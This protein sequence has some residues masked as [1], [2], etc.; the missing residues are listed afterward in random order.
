MVMKRNLLLLLFISFT[1]NCLHAQLNRYIIQFKNK[2]TNPYSISNPSAYL[3][4]KA[5]ARR[6]AYSIAIDSTDLPVTPRYVDSV[7]LAGTVTILNVSK[8]LNQVSIQTTDAAAL[9]KINSLTFVQSVTAIAARMNNASNENQ[10]TK[11]KFE[12]ERKLEDAPLQRSN[13][14]TS[15]FFSYGNTYNE[16]HLHNGEF[17]HNIGMR[18][19]N[20]LVAV[21]DAGFF[22]YTT[23]KAFDSVV[24][25]NQVVQT[26]D[27]VAREAN[28]V[29]DDSHGMS[30]FSAIGGN[31]PGSFVG[32]APKANFV[33]YR[34]E[35]VSSE[36][37]IEEHNWACG[38]ERADS[39][40]ADVLSTSLGYT[41]FDNSS[42]DH[43]YA[44]MN[45][46]TNISTKAA[47]IA[48]RKGLLSFVAAGNDGGNSWHYLSSPGDADSLVTV[49]AVGTN[50]V[51]GGFSSYGPSSDGR[52]KP[53]VA[54]LGVNVYVQN[55]NNTIGAGNGTSY[56]TPKMAG[57]GTC[58]WQAF[59]EYNNMAIR[60]ALIK[61]SSIYTTPDDRIGYGIPDM[62]KAF[63]VL[64]N[65]YAKVTSASVGN[66]KTTIT[67]KTKDVSSM[68]F[69]IERL[70]PGQT[71]YTKIAEVQGQGSILGIHN[72]S[73]D[74][75]LSNVP[76]GT[77]KYRIKQV[78]DTAIAGY[79][80]TYFDSASVI[81]ATICTAASNEDKVS[82]MP[83]PVAGQFVLRVET[84]Y[85]VTNLN[86]RITDMKGRLMQQQ[87][88]S[89]GIGRVD[90]P[91]SS[92]YF[93]RGSYTISVYNGDVLIG[94]TRLV[95]L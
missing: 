33:L 16:I 88:K 90:F 38:A 34:T 75:A 70:A 82:I 7:R 13:N 18:G 35:D 92:N 71:S 50:G 1:G 72:Y 56:A 22:H 20:M 40:G 69:E 10:K 55:P 36:Y 30:C 59:P 77:I 41:T 49:G 32:N 66:C 84:S 60:D 39:I 31:I 2:G 21:L 81:L 74:D 25:N 89:K 29:E 94:N 46:R 24:A 73:Y 3:S 78:I 79:A 47:V 4:S 54:S 9:N 43:T 42:L 12:L 51:V 8:W 48:N 52:I 86:I 26:W 93:A 44:S 45:G 53:E 11:D 65:K 61:S 95:K 63:I 76:V 14:T 37:P 23:L 91:M 62:K 67:W 87:T 57:L 6:T 83:N 80:A 68:K 19:Q 5:Q 28:V 85:A 27:F 64:L 17:L 15:D 58:L